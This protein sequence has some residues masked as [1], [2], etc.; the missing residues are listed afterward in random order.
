MKLRAD[1][2]HKL[3]GPLPGYCLLP[4]YYQLDVVTSRKVCECGCKL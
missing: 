3:N 1:L 2:I 4:K